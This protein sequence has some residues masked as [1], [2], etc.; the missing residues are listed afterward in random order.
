MAERRS[1]K[2]RDPYRSGGLRYDTRLGGVCGVIP[3]IV[4]LPGRVE[5]HR[6][7]RLQ[8]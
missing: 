7:E 8:L 5:K 4:A 2:C 3:H 6:R 1:A